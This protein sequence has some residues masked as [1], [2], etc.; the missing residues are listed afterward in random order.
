MAFKEGGMSAAQIKQYFGDSVEMNDKG[1]MTFKNDGDIDKF[2]GDKKVRKFFINEMGR[3]AS[4]FDDDKSRASDLGFAVRALH[5][6]DGEATEEKKPETNQW[7]Q[8]MAEARA[9]VKAYDETIL[10]NAGDYITGKK[11]DMNADYL[12]SY[13]L[14]LANELKPTNADGSPRDSVIQD[15]K[16]EQAVQGFE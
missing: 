8:P 10:T 16:E 1:S 9:G 14:N 7:S 6:G 4:D 11:K 13:K 5:N 3:S 15:K 2:M 12:K